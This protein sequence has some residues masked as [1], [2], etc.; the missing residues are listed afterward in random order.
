MN[1]LDGIFRDSSISN[2]VSPRAGGTDY[3]RA[4]PCPEVRIDRPFH[5]RGEF[6]NGFPAGRHGFSLKERYLRSMVHKLIIIGLRTSG[7]YR[8][9]LRRQANLKPLLIDGGAGQ[10]QESLGAG[11]QLMIT[12]EVENYPGFE[13]GVQGPERWRICAAR[14][15]GST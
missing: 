5:V 2:V 9:H 6:T 7:L 1:L 4:R 11:G 8:R 15:F 10:G 12:T 3:L 13:H 14:R